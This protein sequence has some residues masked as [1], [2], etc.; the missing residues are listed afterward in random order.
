MPRNLSLAALAVLSAGLR[1]GAQ[2]TGAI[3]GTVYDP[4][5]ASVP[6]ASLRLVET[7]TSAVRETVSETTGHYAAF[8]LLPG[9]YEIVV[10]HAGFRDSVRSGIGLGAGQDVRVDFAL[11]LGE[12][13][14]RVV[15]VGE[16]SPISAS[17]AAVGAS[18]GRRE[19]ENLPV[20]GR[21]VFELALQQPGV[22]PS[23]SSKRNVLFGPG[24]KVSAN[25]LRPSQNGFLL[26]GTRINDS[27][28]SVAASAA[29]VHLGV[30]GISELRVI[31]NPFSAEYGRAAG[32]V[33]AAV[34]RSG[35]NQ[36]H[37][38]VY[39]F[40][41][42]SAVDAKNFFDQPGEPI[43]PLRR[44]QFGGSAGG[45]VRRN[46][47]FYF[48]NYEAV[49]ETLTQ[50][51]R[52]AVPTAAS[53]SG[54]LPA[55]G[56]GTISVPV[57]AGVR[58][59]LD[60]YPLPNGR[61]FGDG[62]A[63][64]VN[65]TV[66]STRE[67]YAAGKMDLLV[68]SGLR[69]SGRYTF[70]DGER[71]AP[72]SLHVFRLSTANRN[73]FVHSE[74]EHVLSPRAIH[75]VRAAFSR[76]N[77]LE[78]AEPRP[79]IAAALSFIPG[80]SLGSL[81][82]TGLEDVGTTEMK[83]RPRRQATGDLQLNDDLVY[84]RGRHA[85][86]AGA[87]FSRTGFDQRADFNATGNY[88]FNSLS[89]LLQ[90]RPRT[91]ILMLPDS[92]TSRRW[93]QVQ[94]FTYLQDEFRMGRRLSLS[95]GLRHESA[96]TPEEANGKVSSVRDP[97]HD[98]A[99]TVG[100]PIFRNP[101][102]ATF[103]PRAGLA[104][105]VSGS[106][107]TVVRAGAGLFVELVGIR[108]V[109][110]AG[111]RMPPFYKRV[112]ITQPQFPNLVAALPST[113]PPNDMEAIAFNLKQPRVAQ[114][115]FAVERQL[116]SGT[117]LKLAYAG[118][119]GTHL[120]GAVGNVNPTSPQTLPDGRLYFPANTA[121]LNP[122]LGQ[123]S[124]RDPRFNSFHHG[125]SAGIERTWRGGLA[126]RGSYRWSKTIDETSVAVNADFNTIDGVMTIYDYRRNRGPSDFDLRHVFAANASYDIPWRGR[127]LPA[128]VLGGWEL[129]ALT[130]ARTGSH[131][132]PT[133]GFDRARQQIAR[134]DPGQRPD[135][136]G[137]P[138]QNLILG[139]PAQYFDPAAFGLPDAGFYGSLGRNVLTGPGEFSVDL[140][141]HKELW[142]TERQNLR[143]R[144]EA[145]NVLNR[146]NF[147]LPSGLALFNSSLQ[148]L[149]TAGRITG[150][151]TGARQM[152]IALR[153]AF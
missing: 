84:V 140:G 83:L 21:D 67:D 99:V 42:N 47:L 150:T 66:Q 95:V 35:A 24:I 49:R 126:F 2:T 37:G 32:A 123:I 46:R 54:L 44:N 112:T 64:S 108:E 41:H 14:D 128:R 124:Y 50:T 7:K 106:G 3:Q 31:T 102:A 22:A 33:F 30:E 85:L 132:N 127:G 56:G 113:P 130:T 103:S 151:T 134:G 149:G 116:H 77:N 25:G 45:P 69:L 62:T 57:A 146:P 138:G 101:S 120:F 74:A 15:V 55:A 139:D 19:L 104:W 51:V 121:R 12:A 122:A 70:D 40:L 17:A 38:S 16:A 11:E 34:T 137:R 133:A 9:S 18:V 43:P 63:E 6:G 4:T 1:L 61:D 20:S 98:T 143:L 78:L 91:G 10:T 144:L 96:S 105:D 60:L 148:R 119:R 115:Q 29:G 97:A 90:G 58:P 136:I 36:H 72:D 65:Q 125:F 100:G 76:I 80:R 27:S 145:F 111:V 92:D 153:W 88:Q 141:L 152:Q 118:S 71:G 107:R 28:S 131:F 147:D 68:S 59:Y 5:G 82:V 39:E 87:G 79:D 117:V 114:W 23:P 109:L 26:D 53:R 86:R 135:Y 110:V 142:K 93:S 81:N 48:G 94:F 73:Q 129:N 52:P 13:R 89:D 75:T 8:R